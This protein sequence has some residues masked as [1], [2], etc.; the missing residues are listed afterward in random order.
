META[1]GEEPRQKEATS[2]E[3][4]MKRKLT[5]CSDRDPN[6]VKQHGLYEDPASSD[7]EVEGS[8][9]ILYD[10]GA[11]PST[12]MAREQP[13]D[14]AEW[15]AYVRHTKKPPRLLR[16][17][18]VANIS[19]SLRRKKPDPE[20]GLPKTHY[21]GSKPRRGRHMFLC[22]PVI[23]PA[24]KE[25]K[26]WTAVMSMVDVTYTALL[27]PML[28][29]FIANPTAFKWTSVIDIMFGG[30]FYW[31]D[32][33]MRFRT[34]FCVT[35]NLKRK[36][37]MEAPFIADSYIR[38][39][40]FMWDF[41][42]ALPIIPQIVWLAIPGFQNY[43][44]LHI[45][46][47][48]RLARMMRVTQFVRDQ[49]TQFLTDGRSSFLMTHLSVGHVML[50]RVVY[51]T[52]WLL[53]L[54]TCAWIWLATVEGKDNSY[55]VSAGNG[56]DLSD[57]DPLRQWVGT[58]YY[59]TMQVTTVGNGDIVPNTPVEEVFSCFT[60]ITG[61]VLFGFA[62]SSSQ[63]LLKHVIKDAE[64]IDMLRRKM[65]A[66]EAWSRHRQ[67]P[68][69]LY[70]KLRAF[71]AH[72]WLDHAEAGED[73]MFLEL[74]ALLQAEIAQELTKDA[75]AKSDILNVLNERALK[76][77][78]GRLTPESIPAGHDICKEGDD[79]DCLWLLQ[80]GEVLALRHNRDVELIIAPGILG[81]LVVVADALDEAK[82]RRDPRVQTTHLLHK[83]PSA[84]HLGQG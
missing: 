27:M 77:F 21:K 75:L 48:L 29:A 73:G 54:L 6:H 47:L 10:E 20:K 61:V 40:G 84:L 50:L 2:P 14:R 26:T 31:M 19:A 76:V 1:D 65:Q 33:F 72:I 56:T 78:V 22:F 15:E 57:K 41:A 3:A 17:R 69:H 45:I 60:M 42:A 83:L 13:V 70:S 36:L 35:F 53:N 23:H 81:E 62:I 34:G 74:P 37:V 67:V 5:Q 63:E 43:L 12:L 25:A 80:E 58:L 7:S 64:K 51:L 16:H 79:A 39:A 55:L 49:F 52:V 46:L 28:V 38:H 68:E 30:F 9:N 71:Y 8:T 44:P 4:E 82:R 66:V 24:S 18:P 32:I 59:V 11:I